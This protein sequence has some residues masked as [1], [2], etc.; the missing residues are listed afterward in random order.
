MAHQSANAEIG[1]LVNALGDSDQTVREAA[2]AALDALGEGTLGHALVGATRGDPEAARTLEKL[3][4]QGDLRAVPVLINRLHDAQP[5]VRRSVAAALGRLGDD[6]AVPALVGLLSDEDDRVRE[7]AGG[8]LERLGE[9]ALAKCVLGVLKGDTQAQQELIQL[10]EAGDTRVL[11]PLLARLRD[12]DHHVRTAICAALGTLGDLQAL[13]HLIER[14]RDEDWHV[15]HAAVAALGKLASE[16]AVP[17]LINALSDEDAAVRHASVDALAAIGGATATESLR[18]L[19]NDTTSHVRKAAVSAIGKMRVAESASD[20]VELLADSD[21]EVRQ[22]ANDALLALGEAATRPLLARLRDANRAVR[23][24]V[25]L[26]LGSLGD[27]T[28]VEPLIERLSDPDNGVRQ[29]ASVALVR[30]GESRL[31][32]VFQGVLHGD[33]S[34]LDEL[35]RLAREGDRRLTPALIGRLS[36]S[37]SRTVRYAVDAVARTGD[38]RAGD[39][40]LPILGGLDDSLRRAAVLALAAIYE[41]ATPLAP[42]LLCGACF[43]RFATKSGSSP[44]FGTVRLYACRACGRAAKALFDARPCVG[45]LDT[46]M[47]DDYVHRGGTLRVNLLRLGKVC[48]FDSLEIGACSSTQVKTL[49]QWVDSDQD[50]FRV[51]RYRTLPVTVRPQAVLSES[52]IAALGDRF[53]PVKNEPPTSG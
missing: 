29:A 7:A 42:S 38:P 48:D 23:Q 4:R 39:A 25:C 19:L 35:S 26:V 8:A 40:L 3:A 20:L 53:G 11:Q 51:P 1:P 13:P 5:I 10:A 27:Q 24:S 32:S 46:E 28:A 34:A 45:V 18:Q 22:A 47:P 17:A 37:D 49:C 21:S 43:T 33:T 16:E 2:A 44:Q 31:G 14:L 41:D 52:D 30:L 6:R 36:D 12:G 15:R 9:G 50:S